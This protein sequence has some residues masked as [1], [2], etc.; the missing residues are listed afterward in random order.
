MDAKAQHQK[1]ELKNILEAHV[2]TFEQI[3]DVIRA[4]LFQHQI[5]RIIERLKE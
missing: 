2:L 4:T 1:E 5:D 3:A